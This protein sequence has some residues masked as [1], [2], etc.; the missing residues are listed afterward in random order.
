MHVDPGHINDCLLTILIPVYNEEATVQSALQRVTDFASTLQSSSFDDV[1][2]HRP[3][4]RR[5]HAL[6][7]Y[8]NDLATVRSTTRNRSIARDHLDV[9][10]IVVND[11]ST[12]RTAEV[13]NASDYDGVL[14]LSHDK[15][16]GKGAA[17]QTGIGHARGRYTVIHD[18]DNEY[19][20]QDLRKLLTRHLAA[21]E[22]CAVFG[23]RYLKK[24]ASQAPSTIIGYGVHLL[25]FLARIVCQVRLTDICTCYKMLP[26]HL[27]RRLEL[28][29]NGFE[30]CTELTAKLAALGTPIFEVP[31]SYHP[32]TY[33]DGKKIRVKDGA[34]LAYSLFRYRNWA[35]KGG[36][37]S[38]N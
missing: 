36:V 3:V 16:R 14:V 4:R 28:S 27:M 26:T 30:F 9:Q 37:R 25:N 8:P 24:D 34:R 31:I 10:I 15:N 7:G 35:R 20:P 12:D 17:I 32:R 19:D 18:A 23:S 21:D 6:V 1:S 38:L 33:A 22:E 11:G 29:Q 5:E 13:I 2:D